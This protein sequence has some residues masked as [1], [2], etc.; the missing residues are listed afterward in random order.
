M[1]EFEPELVDDLGLAD[2]PVDGGLDEIGGPGWD[3]DVA[4]EGAGG[5]LSPSPRC[6]RGRD[7]R[8]RLRP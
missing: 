2:D 4:V 5:L 8:W 6:G 1:S 7:R 3:E